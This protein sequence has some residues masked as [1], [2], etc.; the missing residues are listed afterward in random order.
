MGGWVGERLYACLPDSLPRLKEGG[1]EEGEAGEREALWQANI[2]P[3]ELR[4]AL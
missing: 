3:L 2:V 1:M 4:Q